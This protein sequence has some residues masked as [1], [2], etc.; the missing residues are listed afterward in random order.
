MSEHRPPGI[1]LIVEAEADARTAQRLIDRCAC[2]IDWVDEGSLDH[3]RAWSQ[4]H[5]AHPWLLWKQVRAL[6]KEHNIRVQG[7]FDGKPGAP[8][9]RAARR[10]LMLIRKLGG[11]E[12]A[13]LVRDADNQPERLEG[14]RQARDD[15]RHG[16]PRERIVIGVAI[17]EREA[18]HLCGYEPESDAE[19]QHLANERK[20]LG[21]DPTRKPHELRGDGKRSA[22]VCLDTL[23]EA[24]YEREAACL[25][26]PLE[27]L[28]ERG[29]ACGLAP[30]LDEV[31]ARILPLIGAPP[32]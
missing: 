11:S 19:H 22:K 2:E 5:P 17:P 9:A 31:D 14:L 30:F 21:F 15:A 25:D 10:A 29:E 16:L 24:S 8:D 27:Q 32:S 20:R 18:W 6:C 23:T 26:A 4:L 28:R 3:L 13:V 1:A 12:A 7:Q